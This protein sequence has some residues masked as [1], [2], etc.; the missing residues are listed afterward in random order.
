MLKM[1]KCT[2]ICRPNLDTN[3]VDIIK[4]QEDA[5]NAKTVKLHTLH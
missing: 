3:T 5:E 4:M 1:H 2:Q